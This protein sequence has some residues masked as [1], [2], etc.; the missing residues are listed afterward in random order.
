LNFADLNRQGGS[1]T[2]EH[3]LK[4]TGRKIAGIR[5][6][7]SLTQRDAAKRSGIS[8]RY[9]QNIELG[10]ANI[11][12]STLFRIARFFEVR[13]ADLVPNHFEGDTPLQ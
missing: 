2:F 5:K 7:K 10:A 3:F 4:K 1:M 11:T 9:F 8:Y 12:L 6:S 13:V